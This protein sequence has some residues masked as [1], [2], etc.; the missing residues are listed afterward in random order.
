LEE[1]LQDELKIDELK[2]DDKHDDKHWHWKK[3]FWWIVCK[4][5]WL[6]AEI[7]EC[8]AKKCRKAA[9]M[10]CKTSDHH[11]HDPDVLW[12]KVILLQ[13]T[14]ADVVRALALKEKAIALKIKAVKNGVDD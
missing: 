11:H 13:K 8:E 1:G 5:Q 2:H 9:H 4:E 14:I 12:K 3:K 6:I 7:L 10:L